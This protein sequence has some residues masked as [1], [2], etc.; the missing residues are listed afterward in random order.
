MTLICNSLKCNAFKCGKMQFRLVPK[1][2]AAKFIE[3]WTQMDSGYY[4]TFQ[5]IWRFNWGC[6]N[7]YFFYVGG[8]KTKWSL[9]NFPSHKF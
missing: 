4:T 6:E 5:I 1:L 3:I 9:S 2:K 8:E 7:I